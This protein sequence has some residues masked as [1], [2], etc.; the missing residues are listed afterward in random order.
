MR[1][2]RKLGVV[3]GLSA[4]LVAIA[5]Y[6]ILPSPAEAFKGLTSAGDIPGF[7]ADSHRYVKFGFVFPTHAWRVQQSPFAFDELLRRF[8]FTSQ[9]GQGA[10]AQKRQMEELFGLP[11]LSLDSYDLYVGDNRRVIERILVSKDRMISFY[12]AFGYI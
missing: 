3:L 12:E 1:T 6:A 5:L 8:H 7:S 4:V 11:P 10:S 2:L 9:V